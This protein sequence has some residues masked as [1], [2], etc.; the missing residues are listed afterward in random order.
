MNVVI[1]Y[2]SIVSKKSPINQVLF[3]DDSF[4]I[5]K[6]KKF[7]LSKEFSFVSDLLKSKDLKKKFITLDLSSKKKL[8]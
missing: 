1:N 7:F 4:N 6:S 5:S 2:R 3:V 8:F